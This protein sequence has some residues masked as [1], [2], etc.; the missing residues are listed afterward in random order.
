[1]NET[2]VFLNYLRFEKRYSPHTILSYSN[3]LRQFFAYA[4]SYTEKG[5]FC[6]DEKIIRLWLA[7]LLENQVSPRSVNRKITALRSFY[8]FLIREKKVTSDPMARIRGPKVPKHL[9]QFVESVQMDFLLEQVEFGEG[10][11]AVRDQLIIALFY[12][13]G[14]RLSELVGLTDQDVRLEEHTIR[15]LGKRNKERLIPFS[16]EI[17]ILVKRYREIRQEEWEGQERFFLTGKGQPVYQKLVYRV[18]H[19]YLGMVTTLSKK[20]PH[21]IRHTFATHML[22]NGADLNAVKELLGHASLAA[23]QVYTHNTFEKLK[24]VY[25]QA[26]PRAD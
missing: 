12:H 17:A 6:Q 1:M 4:E 18:V 14:I 16:D 22:N 23:T 19:K 10:F 9:P 26:H 24:K 20:S 13:T 25:K 7:D 3:D 21:V 8:R 5:E 2:E 11:E 15:V